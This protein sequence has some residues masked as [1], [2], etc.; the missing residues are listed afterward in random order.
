M[1]A[2]MVTTL[3]KLMRSSNRRM[4]ERLS[5]ESRRPLMET[6]RERQKSGDTCPLNEVHAGHQRLG[7]E[8]VD[9]EA[10]AEIAR[11]KDTEACALGPIRRPSDNESKQREKRTS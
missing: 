9:G 10:P 5:S 3:G 1:I 2:S 6:D 11:E 7:F 4:G 8:K